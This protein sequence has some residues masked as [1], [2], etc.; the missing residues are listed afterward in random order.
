LRQ[1]QD[2]IDQQS[3]QEPAGI[4]QNRYALALPAPKTSS[5]TARSIAGRLV[6]AVVKLS[7]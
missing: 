6:L 5:T 3:V 7:R 2:E 4:K 1:V